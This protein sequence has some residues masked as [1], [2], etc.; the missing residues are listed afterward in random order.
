MKKLVYLLLVSLVSFGFFSCNEKED[1][2][3]WREANIAAYEKIAMDPSYELLKG[4]PGS[5]LGVYYKE[6]K[7]GDGQLY[8]IQTSKVKALYKGSYYDKSVFDAGSSVNEV[9]LDITLN[10]YP[11]PVRG[12]STAMQTMVV[13]DKWEIV[14]PYYLG[15]GAADTYDD[16][17]RM[18]MRGYTTLFFEIELL[19]IELHP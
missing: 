8:P 5:P 12:L 1:N 11:I 9:P 16:Y 15:Y 18:V 13:G 17:G 4:E 3:E 14:V 6:V 10:G 19:E 2:T 7:K